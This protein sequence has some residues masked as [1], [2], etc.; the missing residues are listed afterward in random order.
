MY[1]LAGF[2]FTTTP[3]KEGELIRSFYLRKHGVPRVSSIPAL[4]VERLVDVIAMML[5]AMAGVMSYPD[6]RWIVL[7]VSGVILGLLPLIYSKGG[8]R[9]LERSRSQL[10]SNRLKQANSQLLELL[11]SAAVL[12]RTSSL[13]FG[14]APGVV[15]WGA[16]GVAFHVIFAIL[17]IQ[18]TQ[19]Q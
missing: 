5:L 10:A 1:Y 13:F 7:L 4:F 6:F 11:R 2:G 19:W 16:E 17:D 3:G 12:L 8:Y 15:S 18:T 14:L 9:F